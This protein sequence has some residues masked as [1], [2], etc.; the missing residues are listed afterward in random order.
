MQKFIQT[1]L[2][3]F[4]LSICVFK[5]LFVFAAWQNGTHSKLILFNKQISND[6]ISEKIIFSSFNN[7]SVNDDFIKWNLS[8]K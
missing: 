7:Y 5:F 1:F 3:I 4:I 8:T 2:L 6:W